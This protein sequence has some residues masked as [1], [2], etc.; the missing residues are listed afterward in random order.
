[1]PLLP[2]DIAGGG[3]RE[4]IVT[5]ERVTAERDGCQEKI[6]DTRLRLLYDTSGGA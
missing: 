1:M 5:A 4:A 2:A 3:H 6:L